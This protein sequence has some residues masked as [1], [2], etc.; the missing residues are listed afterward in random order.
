[1]IQ[2]QSSNAQ[3]YAEQDVD[4][5]LHIILGY[6]GLYDK[7]PEYYDQFLYHVFKDKIRQVVDT[8]KYLHYVELKRKQEAGRKVPT[9]SKN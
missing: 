4:E 8:K 6:Q 2:W 7:R 9:K 5:N 3:Y 1:M